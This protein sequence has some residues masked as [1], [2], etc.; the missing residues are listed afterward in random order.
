MFIGEI[1]VNDVIRFNYEFSEPTLTRYVAVLEVKHSKCSSIVKIESIVG[2]DFSRNGIRKF[3]TSGI[4]SYDIL[5]PGEDERD[6]C[7]KVISLSNMPDKFSKAIGGLSNL[8]SQYR[9]EGYRVFTNSK[10]KLLFALL[11]KPQQASYSLELTFDDNKVTVSGG[12]DSVKLAHPLT[13]QR[14]NNPFCYS[15]MSRCIETLR[16]YICNSL[17]LK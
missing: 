16:H 3:K 9:Y 4:M 14:S 12:T 11:I 10:D 1:R 17:N 13:F 2:F 8:E 15:D 7:L 5:T 6:Y